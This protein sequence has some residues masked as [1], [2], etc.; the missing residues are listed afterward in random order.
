MTTALRLVLFAIVGLIGWFAGGLVGALVGATL[1]G[2]L[3]GGG[4]EIAYWA[5]LIGAILGAT[6][7]IVWLGY[8]SGR[9]SE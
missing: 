5:A 4:G 6:L 3:L 9:S 1:G 8:L 2:L 7:P